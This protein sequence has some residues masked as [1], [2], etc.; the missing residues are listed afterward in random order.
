MS[1]LDLLEI[2]LL[3]KEVDDEN[4]NILPKD[5]YKIFVSY[6]RLDSEISVNPI[7][8]IYRINNNSHIQLNEVSLAF[9][10]DENNE[11]IINVVWD[12]MKSINFE[13]NFMYLKLN[14]EFVAEQHS[15]FDEFL[16]YYS[17]Q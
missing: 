6:S 14:D 8:K 3:K 10:C 7:K 2:L 11:L 12:R 1:W 15:E 4:L 16:D 5:I 13:K 17:K 9:D